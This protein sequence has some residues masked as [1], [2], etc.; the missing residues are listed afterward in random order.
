MADLTFFQYTSKILIYS[1]TWWPASAAM[2]HPSSAMA[3]R[4]IGL[5]PRITP[6]HVMSTLAWHPSMRPASASAE[7]PP[8]TTECSAPMRA[9]ASCGRRRGGG[10]GESF[11]SVYVDLCNLW[12]S[13]SEKPPNTTGCSAPMREQASCGRGWV[14][15]WWWVVV[16]VG[17]RHCCGRGRGLGALNDAKGVQG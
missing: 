3:F 10:R 6:E 14:G 13:S 2:R 1:P 8:N 12:R 9:Q 4:L 15:G 17:M 11:G 5:E 7:K 16:G